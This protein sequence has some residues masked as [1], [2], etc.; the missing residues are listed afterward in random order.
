MNN[1]DFTHPKES[2]KHLSHSTLE[3]Y[4]ACPIR[5]VI[6]MFGDKWSLIVLYGLGRAPQEPMRYSDIQKEMVDCS[7]KMLI[8]TLKRL[9]KIGLI[10]RDQYPVMPPRVEYS[11]TELG[12]SLM[13]RLK[14]LLEWAVEHFSEI[15]EAK[16]TL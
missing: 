8:Q 1:N 2:L 12:Q 16:E 6:S 14:P 4:M 9:E 5:N 3:Q 10:Y 7:P 15:T 11:L 13:P